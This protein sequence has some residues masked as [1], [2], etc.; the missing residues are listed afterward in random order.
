MPLNFFAGC[1]EAI[2][3]N[4]FC[5][6]TINVTVPVMGTWVCLSPPIN[7]WRVRHVYPEGIPRYY[8][9][10]K[11]EYWKDDRWNLLWYEHTHNKD[12]PTIWGCIRATIRV[13]RESMPEVCES[14]WNS[15]PHL[16]AE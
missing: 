2:P 1:T 5:E 14:G 4:G 7:K 10:V 9:I 8:P 3:I 15:A 12:W 13:S 11:V 16:K 6:E